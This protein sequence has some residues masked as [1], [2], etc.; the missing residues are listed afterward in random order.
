MRKAPVNTL[1]SPRRRGLRVLLLL[2]ALGGCA[3]APAYLTMGSDEL[4]AAGTRAFDEESWDDAIQTL[5][6][7]VTTTPGDDR[8]PEARMDIARSYA[9][10]GEYL[11]AASEFQRFLQLHPSH[12][13]APEASLGICKAYAALAPDPQRDQSYTRQA[14]D[15]CA[16]TALEFRGLSVAAEADSIRLAMVDRLAE[17]DFEVADFYKNISPNS[18]IQLYEDV[19]ATYPDTRWAPRALLAMYRAYRSLGWDP[20]AEETASRLLDRY[21]DSNPSADLRDEIGAEKAP[22]P[23][24]AS[25]GGG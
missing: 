12:G 9:G 6:R 3:S 17:S 24:A 7:F 1:R 4:W 21:P 19:V 18:A 23:S 8:I 14:E 2:A 16:G 25:Q 5:E 11:T 15:A 10:R 13:L 22:P 20:E